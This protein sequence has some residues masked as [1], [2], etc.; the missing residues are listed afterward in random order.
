MSPV[1]TTSAPYLWTRCTFARGVVV[2]MKTRTGT[3]SRLAA[4]ATAAPWFPP[5]AA[6]TPA[7]G[8]ASPSRRWKAPRTLNEPVCW[9]SS[10]FRATGCVCPRKPSGNSSTGVLRTNPA[11]RSRAFSTSGLPI[12]LMITSARPRSRSG[13]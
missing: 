2:G 5:E 11:M 6:T 3:P 9:W 8:I 1:S 10:S 7:A 4:K 12:V 13:V